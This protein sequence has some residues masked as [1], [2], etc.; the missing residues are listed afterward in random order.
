MNEEATFVDEIRRTPDDLTPRLIYA[1]YLED[2]GDP[3]GELIRVQCELSEMAPGTPGRS[4]RM[5]RERELLESYADL[6]LQPLR[7]LGVRGLSFHSFER[8]LLERIRISAVDYHRNWERLLELTPA[9]QHL[10]LRSVRELSEAQFRTLTF[11]EQIVSLDISAGQ[12]D[13]DTLCRLNVSMTLAVNLTS[14]D[15]SGNPVGSA[16]FSVLPMTQIDS[17]N[18]GYCAIT[19]QNLAEQLVRMEGGAGLNRLAGRMTEIVLRGNALAGD[20]IS[21]LTKYTW[22]QLRHLDLTS[23]QLSSLQRLATPSPFPSLES[24][25]IRN[26]P[27]SDWPDQSAE[28]SHFIERLRVMDLR[29]TPLSGKSHGV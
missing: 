22:S 20:G 25:V 17:L 21:A 13:A 26:N 1:D 2:C 19:G 5:N 16:A 28:T 4:E 18:A 9:L 11:P 10:N 29:G 27:I 12:I 24:L 23:C 3:R 8:G 14:L 15:V 6:W 7:E